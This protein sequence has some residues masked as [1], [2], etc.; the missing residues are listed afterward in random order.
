M[1]H[2][3]N[4]TGVNFVITSTKLYLSVVSLSINDNKIFLE[5]IKQIF[6]RT[7]YWN[8]YGTEVTIQPKNNKLDSMIDPAFRNINRQF[9]Q[10]FKVGENYP[11]RNSFLRYYMSLVEIED[12]NALI[13]NK[14]FFD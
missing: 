2:H 3:N 6:K 14:S 4:I 13:D 12:F 11:T 1:E 8:K 10:S 7:I 9:V 5:N